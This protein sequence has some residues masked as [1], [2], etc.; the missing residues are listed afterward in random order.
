MFGGRL[1]QPKNNLS[2]GLFDRREMYVT[3]WWF[4]DVSKDVQAVRLI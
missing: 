1:L 2:G 3:V 4:S